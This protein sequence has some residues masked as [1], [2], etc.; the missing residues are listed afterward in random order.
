MLAG[1]TDS[2]RAAAPPRNREAALKALYDD[3]YAKNMFPFWA[4]STDVAHDEIKQLMATK[5]AV[6]FVWAYETDIGPILERAV[7]LVTMADTERRS[8]ILVNPGLA[9]R[10]ATVSTMY[11][12]YRLNDANEIMPPHKH[13]PNAVRFGLTGTGNF[14]GVDGENITFGPG[15]M[16]LTPNDTWHNH[17]TVGNERALNLSVLDYPLVEALS[18]LSFAH[19][20]TEVEGGKRVPKKQQTARFP[21]D[22]SQ[23]IY[24]AGGLKPRFARTDRGA[25]YSSPMFVYRWDAMRELLERHKDWDGDPY[26]ALTVEYIDP[27]TGGPVFKTMTFLVQMLRPGER[28]RPVRQTASLLVAP[29]EGRGHSVVEGRRFDWQAFDTLA[30]PGGG[31]YEHVNGSDRAPAFLFIGSDEPA[32]KA[33]DLYK[34]WGCDPN[35]ETVELVG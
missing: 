22:Y 26:D 15:D 35:G 18:A 23:R 34:K 1:K 17:G 25:G 4:S 30:V 24:G 14:T 32:L 3:V 31:W 8:L 16:V 21:S 9:P 12:A 27:T 7:E 19:D 2:A 5:Q 29:F 28:T 10:R 13:S 20:Y 6:P 11:T 33:F